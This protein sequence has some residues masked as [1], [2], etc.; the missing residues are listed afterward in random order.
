MKLP[1]VLTALTAILLTSSCNK[2]NLLLNEKARVEA[3]IA[4]KNQEIQSMDATLHTYG[5]DPVA[6]KIGLDRQAASLAATNQQLEKQLS[7]MTRRCVEGEA[8]VESLRARVEAYKAKHF[9]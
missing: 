9:R 3:E 7:E 4:K 6:A 2:H 5:G 8:T 1:V